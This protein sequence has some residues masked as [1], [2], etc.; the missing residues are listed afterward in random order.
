MVF[1]IITAG[2][3]RHAADRQVKVSLNVRQTGSFWRKIRSKASLSIHL[4]R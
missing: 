1:V 2:L 4:S 3:S